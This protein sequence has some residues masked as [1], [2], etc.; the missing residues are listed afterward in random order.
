MLKGVCF[1]YASNNDEAEDLLQDTFIKAFNK[2]NSF[3]GKGA[4]GGWLRKIAVN[5][6]LESLRKN[7]IKTVNSEFAEHELNQISEDDHAL[8]N[9]ELEDLV[10]KIQNLSIGYRS[11]FNLYA[12]E[13]YTHKEIAELLNIS[14]GT[15]KSQFSRA[16]L[17]LQKMINEEKEA[18]KQNLNYVG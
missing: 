1:R 3:S 9:L 6:A 5:T 13:G 14:A 7:K 18:V 10:K 8:E 4:L 11:V 15:S 2:L 16:R 12:I 17:L